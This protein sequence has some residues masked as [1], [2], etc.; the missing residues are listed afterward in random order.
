MKYNYNYAAFQANTSCCANTKSSYQGQ[1]NWRSVCCTAANPGGQT[2]DEIKTHCCINTTSTALRASG[3]NNICC[4]ENSN[5]CC[6]DVSC[7]YCTEEQKYQNS[8]RS[9]CSWSCSANKSHAGET[10]W[11]SACC[12]S[13][14]SGLSDSEW[15]TNC[16][17]YA[18][19]NSGPT[20][21]ARI[22][23]CLKLYNTSNMSQSCCGYL[24]TGDDGIYNGTTYE[25]CKRNCYD[26]S[27]YSS[28]W[29]ISNKESTH[30]AAYCCNNSY[31][32]VSGGPT[33]STWKSY[34][35]KTY[36][37]SS[38]NFPTS[39]TDYSGCC[40][41]TKVDNVW[42]YSPSHT[43]GSG[44]GG[45]GIVNGCSDYKNTSFGFYCGTD[46]TCK[47]WAYKLTEST[48]NVN[49]RSCCT[50][51][52]NSYNNIDERKSECCNNDDFRRNEGATYC[53]VN[54]SNTFQDKC[55][56]DDKGYSYC[57]D[58][59]KISIDCTGSSSGYNSGTTTCSCSGCLPGYKCKV[60]VVE[61]GTGDSVIIL[62]G[63]TRTFT[64]NFTGTRSNPNVCRSCNIFT[65]SDSIVAYQSPCG[66]GT[67]QYVNNPAGWWS[68]TGTQNTECWVTCIKQGN[69]VTCTKGK[70]RK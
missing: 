53:C 51:M 66:G 70:T 42:V 56:T 11:R 2:N 59:T 29:M 9:S 38:F 40:D 28:S 14:S 13:S 26:S 62:E 46:N 36:N 31:G 22:A 27:I 48:S 8:P 45:G 20:S 37:G 58:P 24:G 54:N 32:V 63:N 65:G 39:N 6:Q 15:L 30:S 68:T 23:C 52:L 47:P 16:C 34:C 41:Y 69:K 3:T 49:I 55:C 61:N 1:N 67:V 64:N 5:Q 44:C 10:K 43:S 18:G 19:E 25:P 35:C 21:A 7:S 17:D 33:D 60:D 57:C 4:R 12:S 50:A